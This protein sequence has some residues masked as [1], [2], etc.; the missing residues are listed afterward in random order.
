MKLYVVTKDIPDECNE[1]FLGAFSTFELASKAA[2][3]YL[4]KQYPKYADCIV[5]YST[6]LELDSGF[7]AFNSGGSMTDITVDIKEINVDPAEI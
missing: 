1:R 7:Y 4:E 3:V 2:K 6:C 5:F